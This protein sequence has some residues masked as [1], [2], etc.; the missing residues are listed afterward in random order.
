MY[1]QQSSPMFFHK[2]SC[3][4]YKKCFSFNS[5]NSAEMQEDCKKNDREHM[6]Y[7]MST[8]K[9]QTSISIKLM[10]IPLSHQVE[11]RR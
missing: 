2:F 5:D 8:G 9:D 6:L 3:T 11:G 10:L 4:L 1:I 7:H